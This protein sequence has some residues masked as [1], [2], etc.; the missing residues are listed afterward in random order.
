MPTRQGVLLDLVLTN[1]N[2]LV[3]DVKAGGSLGC[4]DHEMLEFKI[5]SG[6]S[7]AKSKTV[8]LDFWRDNLDV[9]WGLCGG[10]S[11][12]R[13]LEGKGACESQSTFRQHF[14]QPQDRCTAKSRKSG[15]G[16][17]RSVWMSKELMDNI[18]GRKKVNEMWKRA[19]ALGRSLG[20]LS[21]PAGM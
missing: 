21:G 5:L 11:W 3:R 15:K 14:F 8:T 10:I 1:R 13:V 19:S 2:G 17:R 20:M 12:A 18:K 4:S 6:R 9:F 16:G 7:K